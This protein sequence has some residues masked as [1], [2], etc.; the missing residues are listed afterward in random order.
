MQVAMKQG[1]ISIIIKYNQAI[2]S[3]NIN[4]VKRQKGENEIRV[5]Y[6]VLPGGEGVNVVA[7]LG[8]YIT[9]APRLATYLKERNHLN[10]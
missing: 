6:G 9:L 3:S 7:T 1:L 5:Q 4:A 2:K 8:R 10:K